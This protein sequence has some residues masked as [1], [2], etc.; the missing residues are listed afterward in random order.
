MLVDKFA[1]RVLVWFGLGL[2][3]LA[4][5][6]G[7]AAGADRAGVARASSAVARSRLVLTVERAEVGRP[8]PA[9]FLG[10]SL[11]YGTV[12]AYAGTDPHAINPVLVQL[13]RNLVPGQRP[14]LRIGGD[15]TDW[16]WWPVAS[17]PRPPGVTLDLSPGWL[18]TV[19]ALAEQARARLILG[20]N[21]E[22]DIPAIA[23]VEARAL[24]DG[25]GRQYVAALEIG[26]EPELYGLLP[27]YRGPGG[28]GVLGRSPSYDMQAYT[29]EFSRFRSAL[30]QVPL[31]G[32]ATG[33][34]SWLSNAAQLLAAEPRLGAVTFHVYPLNSMNPDSPL[35]PTVPHLLASDASRRPLR[36]LEPDVALAHSH[37]AAFRI[38]E[39]N[40]VCCGGKVGVSDTFASA[41][42]ALDALF[43]AAS[44]GVD[45]VNIHTHDR[46]ANKLFVFNK[47]NGHW[48]AMVHPVYYGLLMFARAALP[49]AHL[50]QVAGANSDQIRSWATLASDGRTRL[51]LINDSLA[52]SHTVVVRVPAPAPAGRA[53]LERLHAP[54]PYASSGITLAGQ[55]FGSQTATGALTG[56]VASSSL[57]P[58]G[59]HYTV[60]LPAA[61]AAML[62]IPRG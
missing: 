20:V 47:L 41:L 62:T 1:L 43:N 21:L 33:W 37:H 23:A 38:D 39:M 18:A 53:V 17:M 44:A 58:S 14:V 57:M 22:A 13:I 48:V 35:Y 24:L 6:A 16:T 31:M 10:L 30:P 54:S 52:Q 8:I 34:F 40:S 3:A 61:S 55:S 19:R 36:V 29:E 26:N 25:I 2:T 46:T 45:G 7:R 5:S 32:P 56:A 27:W 60:T 12:P 51:V 28:Q 11:E 15:S 9:G 50:L 4:S 59:G 42:W 49:G